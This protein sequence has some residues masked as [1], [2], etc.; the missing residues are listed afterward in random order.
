ML[1]CATCCRAYTEENPIK[2]LLEKYNVPFKCSICGGI[3]FPYQAL[4]G[5][6][7]IWPKPLADSQGKLF[8]PEVLRDQ[9]KTSLGIVLSS[10]KGCIDK[11]TQAYIESEIAQGD[12]VAYDNSVPWKMKMKAPDG[13][14]YDVIMAN[15]LDVNAKLLEIEYEV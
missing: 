3:K 8:I 4:N 1:L 10:G 6:V 12:I 5:I 2:I 11:R 14:E 13:K 15:I 7:F 9:F